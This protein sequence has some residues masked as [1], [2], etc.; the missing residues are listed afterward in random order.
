MIARRVRYSRPKPPY[1]PAYV[2]RILS[3]ASGLP[4]SAFR[5]RV[6]PRALRHALRALRSEPFLL[7]N[8]Y[9][10]TLARQVPQLA[11]ATLVSLHDRAIAVAGHV[12][13]G[14]G[15]LLGIERQLLGTR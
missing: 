13:R 14:I 7:L 12:R 6:E 2:G 8:S 5:I 11:K 10:I 15:L 3:S 1:N 9:L 4:G